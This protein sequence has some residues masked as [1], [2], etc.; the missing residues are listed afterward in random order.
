ME[1]AKGVTSPQKLLKYLSKSFFRIQIIFTYFS[2]I[3]SKTKLSYISGIKFPDFK[4]KKYILKII[5][6]CCK[7]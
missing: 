7:N 4:Q 1:G 3:Y 5:F 2:P 6:K